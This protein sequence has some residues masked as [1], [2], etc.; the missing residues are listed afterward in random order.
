MIKPAYQGAA[1]CR[2]IPWALRA[3]GWSNQI[4]VTDCVA[5]PDWVAELA[6]QPARA[7]CLVLVDGLGWQQ[8]A[9]RLG[10]APFLRQLTAQ[11]LTC[12]FP[13]T[14]AASLGSLGTGQPPGKT[15]LAGYRL[16]DPATGEITS[17]IGWETSTAPDVW[18][19]QPTWF[20]R[21]AAADRPVSQI[22]R[23]KF[24]NSGL[25]LAAFRGSRFHAAETVEQRLA[26]CVSAVKQA[27]QQAEPPGSLVYFYWGDLDRAGHHEGWQSERWCTAL[28]T[29]DRAISQLRQRLPAD[30]LIWLTADHGMV[31]TPPG[32]RWDVAATAELAEGV[33]QVAGEPRA[34]HLYGQDPSAIA[35][36][37]QSCLAEHAWVLT[38]TQAIEH[39]LFGQTVTDH[40]KPM[41]GD[42][43]VAMAG[44]AEVVDSRTA[45]VDALAMRGHHGSLTAGEMTVPLLFA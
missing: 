5:D 42:V 35:A 29:L 44:T 38:K 30:V 11:T 31:D 37:W 16:R 36:R 18:Q 27:L 33:D 8:L 40:V 28:E 32:P 6:D 12:G 34:L 10:H 9:A 20:E 41:L 25:T 2:V 4:A 26:A 43:I 3:L 13:S 24:A 45:S 21:L 14:T 23:P 39:G 19:V 22:G 15:G 1:L 17:L 7:L